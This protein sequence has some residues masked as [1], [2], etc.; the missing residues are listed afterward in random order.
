MYQRSPTVPE[1]KVALEFVSRIGGYI[2]EPAPV[3][4]AKADKQT[5]AKEIKA[6]NKAAAAAAI[7]ATGKPLAPPVAE[8]KMDTEV[9]GGK[10]VN[11]TEMVSR[12]EP[13][14]PW[15][16]LAQSM[17]CSNEFVYLN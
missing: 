9:K 10:V 12:K 16:M 15:V 13:S 6:K 11:K 5:R 8:I 14:N 17:I 4:V 3:P 2:D 7:A 1:A